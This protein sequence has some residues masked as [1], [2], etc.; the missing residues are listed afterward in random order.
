ML[1]TNNKPV[2]EPTV[3][4]RSENILRTPIKTPPTKAATGIC[5]Y[6]TLYIDS[7]FCFPAM[8]ISFSWSYLKTSTEDLPEI[9]KYNLENMPQETTIKAK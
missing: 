9:S 8:C 4:I 6:K 3:P 7:V 2:P 1:T 5:F